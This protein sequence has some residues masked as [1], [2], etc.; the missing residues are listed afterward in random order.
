MSHISVCVLS[1]NRLEFL[2]QSLRTMVETAD[3]PIEIIVHD[4]GS[5]DVDLWE[6]LIQ[7]VERGEI[8]RLILNPPG[9]NEGQGIALNRMFHMAKGDIIIKADHDLIYK[10]GWTKAIREAFAANARDV[11]HLPGIPKIGALGLFKYLVEPV[12]WSEMEIANRGAY[13]ET[14]DFVGSLMAIPRE[15]W[16]EFGPFEERSSAFA[17]DAVFKQGLLASDSWCNA[18]TAG[19]YI[20]NVGF[21]VGPSTLVEGFDSEGVGIIHQINPGPKLVE[22]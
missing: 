18:L 5:K 1:Y 11:A 16:E 8:S 17:E 14:Q 3:E 12:I 22:R 4:D 13:S 7:A 6:F 19:D 21:G 10:P 9:H 2:R 20:E 15:A